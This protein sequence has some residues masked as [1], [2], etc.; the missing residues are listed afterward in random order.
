MHLGQCLAGV[1]LVR[2]G[3]PR[4][5]LPC[6]SGASWHVIIYTGQD[7]GVAVP[8]CLWHSGMYHRENMFTN[9]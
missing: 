3:D 8:L 2:D 9:L 7:V 6:Q 1:A 5:E 4:W